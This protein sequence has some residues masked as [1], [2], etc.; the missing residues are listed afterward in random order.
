MS[1]PDQE[2]YTGWPSRGLRERSRATASLGVVVPPGACME[3]HLAAFAEEA[4]AAEAPALVFSP[5]PHATAPDAWQAVMCRTPEERLLHLAEAY[6]GAEA[7]PSWLLLDAT[8]LFADAPDQM[9]PLLR[10]ALPALCATCSRVEVLYDSAALSPAALAGALAL[11]PML[12]RGGC[13]V[14][15]PHYVGDDVA[16]AA[17]LDSVFAQPAAPPPASNGKGLLSV[18]VDTTPNF[19]YVLDS[20]AR[21]VLVN[22]AFARNCAATPELIRGRR[23]SEV[24][25]EALLADAMEEDVRALVAG[26]VAQVEREHTYVTP[27]G[28]T[29][30]A[31]TYKTPA[32]DVSGEVSLVVCVSSDITH[33]RHA[34]AALRESRERYRVMFDNALVGLFRTAAEDGR[35]LTFNPRFAEMF[36]YDDPQ[37]LRRSFVARDHY[38][39]C[40]SRAQL[41]RELRAKGSVEG[42]EVEFQTRKGNRL[43]VEMYA[44]LRR[45]EN[46]IEGVMLDVTHQHAI[47]HDRRR[48]MTAVE[49][50]D[51]TIVIT[52][53]E[54]N[55]NYTNPAFTRVT[56]YTAEEARGQNPRILKSGVHDND[57]Y[58]GLWRKLTAGQ[59]WQGRMTNRRK[60]G[61]TF[62]EQATI[63]PI[64][65]GRGQPHGY[66]AVK[67]DI[68]EALQQ[69][70][71]LRQSQ[72]MEA[73]G[74][75]AGGIAHDFNNILGIILGYAELTR[76]GLGEA[77]AF[78]EGLEEVLD[79]AKRGKGLVERILAFSR[80]VEATDE[81]VDTHQV[82]Q[83]ALRLLRAS[84]PSTVVFENNL[85][86]NAGMVRG[87]VTLLHQVLL[88]LVTNAAQATAAGGGTVSVSLRHRTAAPE[89]LAPRDSERGWVELAVRDT[90]HGIDAA[91][92]ER[93]FDPF[94]TTRRDGSGTGLG[95]AV[96]HGIVTSLGGGI[97][98][99]SAPGKGATFTVWLPCIGRAHE[100]ARLPGGEHSSLVRGSGQRVLL[101]DDE[102]SLV[103]V[104][105]KHLERLGYTPEGFTD[106]KEALAA[107]EQAPDQYDLLLSDQTMPGL[108]GADLARSVRLLRPDMP[109]VLATGYSESLSA[110]GARQ[111]GAFALLQK[112]VQLTTL[113]RTLADALNG[114]PAH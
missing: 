52:D 102:A 83:Q 107:F 67:R 39:S 78:A 62:V 80:Q 100:V 69:E 40:D 30:W 97:A 13:T 6:L 27:R 94:F 15:N 48:L 93:I 20:E 46:V 108:T 9:T 58:E 2:L 68:T 59:V 23:P 57:F 112:P 55:I 90:G 111:L 74:T 66:I 79:A 53:A 106:P 103:R 65:D 64:R 18:V 88:N 110:E 85:D 77:S 14:A 87:D 37:E 86:P 73:I 33:R 25:G 19:I 70:N 54:G 92:Q 7:Q 51:E 75:L 60:D 61:R 12:R 104:M 109:I 1:L 22:Q 72:K 99:E 76:E 105:S 71:R 3:A 82:T 26:D 4:R 21:F 50:L 35:I 89:G 24:V 96:V 56:G 36:E 38:A 17:W 42:V 11:H 28:E 16:A 41:V 49:Q 47:E 101:V 43:I 91:T 31:A 29:R 114:A 63:C 8:Q 113:S 34:E 81:P 10:G 84:I 5:S 98:V 32:R 95:L 45:T 44:R